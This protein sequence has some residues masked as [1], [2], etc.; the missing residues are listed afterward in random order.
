MHIKNKAPIEVVADLL[1]A[2]VIGMAIAALALDY[3][4]LFQP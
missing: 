3:F 1:L 4:S 2:V